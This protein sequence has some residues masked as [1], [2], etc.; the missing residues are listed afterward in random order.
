MRKTWLEEKQ[1][2]ARQ[3]DGGNP[4]LAENRRP[5]DGNHRHDASRPHDGGNLLLVGGPPHGGANPP[6][7]GGSHQSG[8]GAP[9]DAP[10][11]GGNPQHGG[12]VSHGGALCPGGRNP[13][14]PVNSV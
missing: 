12:G 7:G 5:G 1:H 2:E 11:G 13:A 4:L 8:G 9:S 10:L 6:L 14:V 3:C